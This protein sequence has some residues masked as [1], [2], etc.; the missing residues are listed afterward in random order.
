MFGL[1][2]ILVKIICSSL[3]RNSTKRSIHTLRTFLK[4]TRRLFWH[5]DKINAICMS[6][7]MQTPYP[8]QLIRLLNHCNHI[9]FMLMTTRNVWLQINWII[10]SFRLMRIQLLTSIDLKRYRNLIQW[11]FYQMAHYVSLTG[12]S[13]MVAVAVFQLSANRAWNKAFKSTNQKK[14]N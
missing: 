11:L 6:M 9:L 14:S 7:I 4:T 13:L 10:V 12:I 8:K 5:I 2:M 3:N 1:S